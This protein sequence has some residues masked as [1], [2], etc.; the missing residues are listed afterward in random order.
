MSYLERFKSE[1]NVVLGLFGKKLI[2]GHVEDMPY[3]IVLSAVT[4]APLERVCEKK[5]NAKR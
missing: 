3:C 1:Q 5:L 2:D 4:D